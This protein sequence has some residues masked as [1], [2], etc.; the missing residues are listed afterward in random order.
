[1]AQGMSVQG[2]RMWALPGGIDAQLGQQLDLCFDIADA[3]HVVQGQ[4]LVGEQAGCQ[5]RQSGVL[6]AAG[7]HL[8]IEAMPPFDDELFHGLISRLW[9]CEFAWLS[10]AIPSNA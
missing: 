9:G 4:R 8:A 7:R 5:Q 6:V 10:M 3:G 1:M 2:Q